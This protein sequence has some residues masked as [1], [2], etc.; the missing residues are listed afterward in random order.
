MDSRNLLNASLATIVIAALVISGIAPFDRATWVMEVAPVLIALPLMIVT[1]KSYPL[2]TLLTV[3]I[4]AHALV[5]IAG[6][7]LG[8]TSSMPPNRSLCVRRR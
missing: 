4:T 6:D 7:W 3:L 5:L 1:R 2:T 8:T